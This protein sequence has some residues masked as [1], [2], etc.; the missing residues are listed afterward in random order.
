MIF[1]NVSKGQVAKT[2]AIEQCFGPLETEEVLK[3]ILRK[4]QLQVGEKEREAALSKMRREIAQSLAH[5]SVNP[6]TMRPYPMTMIEKAMKEVH[7]KADVTKPAKRQA[8][9]L[10]ALLQQQMPI[11][12]AKMRL[13][14]SC[15][16]AAF[17]E[18]EPLLS[19]VESK[20]TLEEAGTQLEE[21]VVLIDPGNFRQ[22][23]EVVQRDGGRLAVVALAAQRGDGDND[24]ATA[25]L[26]SLEP[27]KVPSEKASKSP[28]ATA[29]P[30]PTTS[31][32]TTTT[33]TE[34][35]PKGAGTSRR[36]KKKGQ[37]DLSD[38]MGV[39]QDDSD[40]EWKRTGGKGTKGGKGGKKGKGKK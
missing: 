3:E 27:T 5:L 19:T 32:T 24:A 1:V 15:S 39:V 7:F 34:E 28:V 20:S 30:P 35:A 33:T 23:D 40:E 37:A 18:L 14:L 31:T 13:K 26:V 21:C 10:L 8:L 2:E 17:Q 38:L 6:T 22:V 11:E 36:G 16:T 4:G 25:G 12:R 29:P 9:E